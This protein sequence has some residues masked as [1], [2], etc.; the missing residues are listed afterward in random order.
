MRIVV[1]VFHGLGRMGERER[2]RER[3]DLCSC[4]F[5]WFWM[6]E[7]MISRFVE[8]FLVFIICIVCVLRLGFE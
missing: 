6:K 1:D 7:R 2:E 3:G 8:G 4:F 5:S